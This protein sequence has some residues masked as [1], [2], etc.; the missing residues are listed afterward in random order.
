MRIGIDARFFGPESKGLGRY[1]QKL[2]LHLEKVDTE[3]DYVIFLRKKNLD[4]YTPTNPRFKKVCADQQWYSFAEQLIFPF[5]LYKHKCDLVHFLHFNV[6]VL[7][8]KKYI[9]TIH[10]L[11]LLR[12]PTR[13]SS[14]RTAIFYWMKFFMYRCVIMIVLYKAQHIIA[15]SQFTKR[16]ICSQ[17]AYASKKITVIYEAAEITSSKIMHDEVK[18]KNMY[19]IMDSYILY[20]GNAYPHKNLQTLIDAFSEIQKKDLFDLQLVLVGKKDFFYRKIEKYIASQDIKNIII[21]STVSDDVLDVVY[22]NASVFAFPSLYEGFGLPPLEAQLYGVPVVSSDH[23]CM[24]EILSDN[25]ALF[26]DA[27]NTKIFTNALFQVLHNQ[28]LRKE[29]VMIGKNNA[30]KYSWK[31]MARMINNTYKNI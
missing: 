2:I 23:P 26:C 16:D 20:V 13:R 25:G 10:D 31:K 1:T 9:V 4:R 30:R 17:Y 15:V 27:R 8:F 21:L 24:R 14:T 12:H 18:I 22:K 28:N 6:P 5:I 11:I 3:N 19:G 7:Y 29:L